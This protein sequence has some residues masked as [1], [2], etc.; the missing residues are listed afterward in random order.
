[1]Q[2]RDY[3]ES[4]PSTIESAVP[5]ISCEG[6]LGQWMPVVQRVLLQPSTETIVKDMA[7]IVDNSW[8]YR[9]LLVSNYAS[10]SFS[11]SFYGWSVLVRTSSP[12]QFAS[13]DDV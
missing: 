3:R 4:I 9:E 1:M 5:L 7:S 8:T 10:K 13:D 12:L 2:L 6:A 11:T